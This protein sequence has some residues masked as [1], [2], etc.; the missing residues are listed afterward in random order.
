MS[1]WGSH[2]EEGGEL[3]LEYSEE[4]IDEFDRKETGLEDYEDLLNLPDLPD[5]YESEEDLEIVYED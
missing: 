1:G 4:Y 3:E 5:Y 2:Y